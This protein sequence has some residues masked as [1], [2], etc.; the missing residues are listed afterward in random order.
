M[1]TALAPTMIAELEVEWTSPN[2][3][4]AEGVDSS[5]PPAVY[6]RPAGVRADN[7]GVAEY[8]MS[9]GRAYQLHHDGVGWRIQRYDAMT[10]Q[11]HPLFGAHIYRLADASLPKDSYITW[12]PTAEGDRVELDPAKVY[13]IGWNS[14]ED[15]THPPQRSR[16]ALLLTELD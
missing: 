16:T 14:V 8:W 11:R 4:H 3:D 10:G 6:A 5:V 15:L 9:L 2:F 7:D 12:L 13:R 1:S